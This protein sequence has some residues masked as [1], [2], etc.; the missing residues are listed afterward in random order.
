MLQARSS[1]TSAASRGACASDDRRVVG[2]DSGAVRAPRPHH[3]VRRLRPL[4]AVG[5]A[6]G[7]RPKGKGK[8]HAPY[9]DEM[10]GGAHHTYTYTS[11][12]VR[13]RVQVH[14][15]VHVRVRVSPPCAIL[16]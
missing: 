6:A 5:H 4:Q 14:V 7:A 3:A 16:V 2:S 11:D 13:V 1:S 12:H 15:H 9:S 10:G 8:S